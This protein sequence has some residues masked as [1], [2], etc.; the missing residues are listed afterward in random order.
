[1]MV[2]SA[3][4][5]SG[6]SRRWPLIVTALSLLIASSPTRP[7]SAMA[8]TRD[9]AEVA[10]SGQSQEATSRSESGEAELDP[11]L[12]T[13]L[14]GVVALSPPETCLRVDIGRATVYRHQTDRPLIPASTQKMFVGLAALERLG[15]SHRF[16]TR[17]TGPAPIDGVITGDLSLIG[18][19]DPLLSTATYAFVRRTANQPL[20]FLDGL[21]DAVVAAGVRHI[22]GRIVADESRYDT[23][24]SV[25]SWPDRYLAQDQAGPLGALTVNHGFQLELPADGSD[26]PPVRRRVG[27]PAVHAA[28]ELLALLKVRGV[29]VDG[30]TAVGSSAP[31]APELAAI[32]SA[33]L[34]EVV[35]QMLEES[36]N[37]TAEL[38]T[39]EI[40]V[41]A[42][43]GGS[44]SAGTTAVV[45]S[46]AT[47]GIPTA[48]VTMTDGS[49]LD[50]SNRA[51]CDALMGAMAL[52][53]GPEG[54]LGGR[55]AVAG[56][57]GTLRDRFRGTPAEGT[58]HAKTGSLNGVTGLVGFVTMADGRVA[59][60]AYV[61]NGAQADDPRRGQD[62]LGVLLG[63]YRQ[64][65]HSNDSESVVA[66]I[67]P[68]PLGAI[69]LA[70]TP[71]GLAFGPMVEASLVAI[72]QAPESAVD[73]CRAA[74]ADFVLTLTAPVSRG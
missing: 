4:G 34:G 46:L 26:K 44:T 16:R 49:G 7:D 35:R 65:C 69:T 73:P 60:F 72:G 25:P 43:I 52:S 11:A 6:P 20:T 50:R 67:A 24:R 28:D 2:R 31:D 68:Y 15:A 30:G 58:L 62:F 14:D 66:P 5:R 37:T 19:G 56:R 42:G 1:M 38:L 17:L 23:V 48:G 70:A 33:P 59:S 41:A 55:L 63:Q 27:D 40:G 53:G 47:L 10:V 74:G 36:D 32:D 9:Q 61:A 29:I 13:G 12:R 54:A 8:G 51:S 22:T 64:E 18:G 71:W 45:E 21:A 57:T 39:K 3:A